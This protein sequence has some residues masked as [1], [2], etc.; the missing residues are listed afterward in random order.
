MTLGVPLGVR[1]RGPLARIAA[2]F[3]MRS[4]DEVGGGTIFRGKPYVA[5]DGEIAIGRDCFVGSRP[6]QSHFVVMPGAHI[7]IG[8]RVVIS[9]GAAMSA[10]QGIEIGDDTRIG[11]FCV[12]LDNDFH[13]VGDRDAPGIVAP[14]QIGSN[15]TIGARV[16]MLRGTRIGDGATVMSGSTISGV[17]ASG[18]VVTGVPARTAAKDVVRRCDAGVAEVVR[19]VFGLAR[20]PQALDGP[21]VIANWNGTGVIQLLLALEREFSVTLSADRVR[22]AA[23]VAEVSRLV[24]QARGP[25]ASARAAKAGDA[26]ASDQYSTTP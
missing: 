10:L 25:A 22:G 7:A 23:T 13:K 11:P 17:V 5:N 18:A 19:R 4:I 14:V 16:T 1:R 6:V 20:P 15:V 21:G 26:P 24:V 2:V 3:G 8:D 9:Y 12:I